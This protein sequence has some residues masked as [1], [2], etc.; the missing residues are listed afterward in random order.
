MADQRE[1]SQQRFGALAN[2]YVKSSFHSGGP[3][4]D[5]LI[6]LVQPAPGKLALDIATGGGHTALALAKAGARVFATDLTP[7]MLRAARQHIAEQGARA[8]YAQVEGAA[9]PFADGALDIVTARHAPHHFPDMPRF[10][11]E[12]A[13]VVKVG[14]FVG[15][16]DQAAP[17]EA[18]AARY[19]NAW[20]RLRDPSH[21]EQLSLSAWQGLFLD[22][23]L[24]VVHV[25]LISER[26]DFQWWTGMQKNDADT[27]LRLR[28]MMQQAPQAVAAFM[29]PTFGEGEAATFLHHYALVI[30]ERV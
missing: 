26:M 11:E 16:C 21:G 17:E 6:A 2:N 13:R 28:A 14:G 23:G 3:T 7:R 12:C 9:L 25:E 20:E 5:K 18:A 24:R 29:Q 10:V 27:V 1:L 30:G 15:L 8:E 22:A 4:L 19:V